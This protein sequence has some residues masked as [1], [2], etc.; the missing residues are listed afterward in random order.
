MSMFLA[1]G[2]TKQF[3]LLVTLAMNNGATEK[4]IYEVMMLCALELGIPTAWNGFI[5]AK[6]AIEEYK[7][8]I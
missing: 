3:K 7:K 8:G 5:A 6:E 4:E 2:A 1:I